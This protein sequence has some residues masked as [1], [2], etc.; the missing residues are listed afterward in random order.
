MPFALPWSL[1]RREHRELTKAVAL[2][3]RKLRAVKRQT[4]R[5]FDWYPYDSLGTWC[6]LDQMF[7]ARGRRLLQRLSNEPLLDIGCGDGDLA[8]FLE[9]LG[10]R[11]HAMDW[12][13]TNHNGMHGVRALKTALASGVEICEVDLDS[14][15]QVPVQHNGL[16]L[17]L[18]VLY[19]LKNPFFVLEKLAQ[20]CRYCLFST[21]VTRF[22]PDRRTDLQDLPVAYLLDDGELNSDPTNHWIFSEA[23]L[24]RLVKKT[25]WEIVDYATQGDTRRSVPDS[26]R[27]ELRVFGIL[28]STKLN[29]PADSAALLDGWHALEQNRW[30][31]TERR[32][33]LRFEG[34]PPSAAS[35]VLRIEFRVHERLLAKVERVSLAVTINGVRL[36]MAEYRLAGQHVYERHLDPEILRAG[37]VTARF[38]LNASIEPDGSDPRERGLIVCAVALDTG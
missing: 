7:G 24:R 34:V 28:K 10:C 4:P 33:G 31:W 23:C 14:Q 16:A 11:V 32:F 19:H 38:E 22:T 5:E 9:S 26:V 35:A 12:P 1:E 15:F 6:R 13:A 18:G 3:N 30:R 20:H 36:E 8:F 27:H 17:L 2:F 29:D 21:T 25:N 37:P